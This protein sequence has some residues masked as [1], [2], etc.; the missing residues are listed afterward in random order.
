MA[1][2]TVTG[3]TGFVGRSVVR[4]LTRPDISL[5]LGTHRRSVRDAL[6]G[7]VLQPIDLTVP[8]SLAGLCDGADVLIHCASMIGGT[9]AASNAVNVEGTR[10]LLKVAVQ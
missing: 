4:A 3:A 10:S 7:S 2:V 6:P 1:T 8:G 5:R 9:A